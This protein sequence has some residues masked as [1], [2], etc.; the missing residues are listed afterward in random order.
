M[1]P[2]C[3]VISVTPTSS[4]GTLRSAPD[5]GLV[6]DASNQE[7]YALCHRLYF[8]ACQPT[9]C[10]FLSELFHLPGDVARRLIDGI[11]EVPFG[12]DEVATEV[13]ADFTEKRAPILP[14]EVLYP[15]I[16]F[17]AFID[18]VRSTPRHSTRRGRVP[19][20]FRGH[21]HRLGGMFLMMGCPA[22]PI[23]RTDRIRAIPVSDYYNNY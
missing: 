8:V 2:T 23:G 17:M 1:N 5:D 10:P 9:P 12:R 16:S 18:H 11:E 21:R 13:E 7:E 19:L 15:G 20:W 4:L 6:R 3:G 14:E 22:V